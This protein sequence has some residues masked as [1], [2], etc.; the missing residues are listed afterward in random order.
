MRVLG[1]FVGVDDQD[2]AAIRVLDFAGRDAQMLWATFADANEA[3]GGAPEDTVVLIGTAATRDA[4]VRA[5]KGL[6]SRSEQASF[7]LAVVHFSCHG[8]PDGHLLGY[9]AKDGCEIE[10]ALSFDQ[11]SELVACLRASHIVVSFDTC[12]SGQAAGRER[13]G[14][15]R[16][17]FERMSALGRGNLAVIAGAKATERAWESSRVEHGLLTYGLLKGLDGTS[18]AEHNR[19]SITRWL[20]HAV[21]VVLAECR[22]DGVLQTPC[23]FLQWEGD[24]SIPVWLP[25]PRILALRAQR[26]IRPVTHEI[27]SL[28]S[29]GLSVAML[30]GVRGR[31]RG[32]PL[33]DMQVRTINDGGVLAGR[34]VVVAGPTSSGK[35][36]VGELA[37]LAAHA[38]RRKTVFLL[39]SR[40][41]TAEKWAEFRDAF[42]PLGIRSVRS[43]GGVED[44]DAALHTH[45]FH[46]AFL[47]YEKFL[48]FA[49][50]RPELL[51]AIGTVVLDEVHLLSDPHRGRTV[52]L[53]LTLLRWRQQ[54]GRPVQIVALSAALGNM[55]GF[56]QW[57]DATLVRENRRPVPLR[58]GVLG[59]SGR[60]RYRDEPDGKEGEERLLERA[61]VRGPSEWE[62]SFSGRLAQSVIVRLLQ[63]DA[64]QCVLAFRAHKPSTRQLAKALGTLL[65]LERCPRVLAALAPEATGRDD[66][67]A[68]Q[69]LLNCLMAGVGF[70]L[71]DLEERERA[72]IE[73]A[74]RDGELQ[75]LVSTTTLAM[76]INTPASTVVIVD[77][78]RF[79]GASKPFGVG[80]YK[81]MAGRAGRWLSNDAQGGL[82]I[83]LAESDDLV[84]T[85]FSTYVRGTPEPLE[86]QLSALSRGDLVLALLA[87]SGRATESTLIDL[88]KGT[89]DGF[90][91]QHDAAWRHAIRLDVRGQLDDLARDGFVVRH[92]DGTVDLTDRGRVC[93]REGLSVASA[94][95]VLAA[96]DI[97]S[98]A[99]EPLDEV[100]LVALA[101]ITDELDGIY[102]P[103]DGEDQDKWP[104]LL[105]TKV[106]RAPLF[107]VLQSADPRVYVQR[108]KRTFAVV[109]WVQGE[110]LARIEAQFSA[111]Q[112]P[113]TRQNPTA[114]LIRQV[115]S[116][117]CDV[118]RPVGRLLAIRDPASAEKLRA[119]VLGLQ[120]R[121]EFG[122]ARDG[123]PLTRYRLGLTRGQIRK[124]RELE[125]TEF[126]PLR[127]ALRQ[128][129]GPVVAVFGSIAASEL[130]VRMDRRAPR[131][132]ATRKADEAIQCNL[133]D[134]V[135]AITSL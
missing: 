18:I 94:R 61:V 72:A 35:T 79:D 121:L 49:F 10:T 31:T 126:E 98:E 73:G 134:D 41:L 29:Y 85:L 100:A 109:Q 103:T 77:H 58:E 96:A 11:L 89:F 4:I 84:D 129:E 83:L 62:E 104:E 9:D 71:A 99:G 117:T 123:A 68:T 32:Q 130:L 125:I 81:N 69:E 59:P 15:E 16:P 110:S 34:S 6:A 115:A 55:N 80:E 74:F 17:L 23:R 54:H 13:V 33:N 48:L 106:T 122:V 120:P 47:T 91:R 24:A 65:H 118:L 75:C 66:S 50:M 43:F 131:A 127:S 1:L 52:E 51:D 114:G 39:P 135:A 82:S 76:G 102:T 95:R 107:D 28:A 45:H 78:V 60:F 7:D 112:K 111:Y 38:R 113:T 124:L 133:F 37:S 5:L 128:Q 93:G 12:F 70:H 25:G 8:T 116:R 105:R 22:L 132:E 36:L 26:Q 30:D 44:D 3:N 53:L 56:E 87:I 86:S 46:V 88:A 101:Q 90:Q 64:A 40:A 14:A 92:E 19:I 42:E 2:D 108:L 67:R 119:A 97:V 63:E 27:N 21:R 57:L 20:D